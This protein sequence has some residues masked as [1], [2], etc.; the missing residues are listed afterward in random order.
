MRLILHSH[1][2]SSYCHKVLIALYES[3]MPFTAKMVNL[4][5]P[6]ARAA[7]SQ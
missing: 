6:A 3:G 2:L 4:G 1:P 7:K 5:D